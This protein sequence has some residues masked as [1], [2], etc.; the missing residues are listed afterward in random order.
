MT[1]TLTF[2]TYHRFRKSTAFGQFNK[3]NCFFNLQGSLLAPKFGSLI[4]LIR[5]IIVSEAIVEFLMQISKSSP[6]RSLSP[7]FISEDLMDREENLKMLFVTLIIL[8]SAIQV[9]GYMPIISSSNYYEKIY[10]NE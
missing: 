1:L 8:F 7:H 5:N 4:S 6:P 2:T 3:V 9:S 10:K